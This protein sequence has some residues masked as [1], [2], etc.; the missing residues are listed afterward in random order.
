MVNGEQQEGGPCACTRAHV[1]KKLSKQHICFITVNNIIET[2][3]SKPK[4][5]KHPQPEL[6]AGRREERKPAAER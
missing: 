2:K 1:F 5:K 3:T 6:A 4:K